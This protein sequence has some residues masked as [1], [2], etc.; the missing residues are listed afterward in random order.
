MSNSLYLVFGDDEYLVGNKARALVDSLVKPEDRAMGLEIIDG[1]VPVIDAAVAAI[2]KCVD[3]VLTMPMFGNAKVTWFQNVNFLSDN[4]VGKSETVKSALES[5]VK[6][7]SKGVPPGQS[8][9]ISAAKVDKRFAFYKTCK[10]KGELHEFAV[11]E[12]S[13]QAESQGRERVAGFLSSAGLSM[14]S[15]AMD[16]FVGRVGYD[17]RQ[18]VN[19]IEKLVVFAGGRTRITVQDIKAVT[20]SSRSAIAWDLSDAIGTRNLPLA[21]ATL[22]QLLFQKEQPVGLIAII[23]SRIK[24]LLIYRHALDRKWLVEKSSYGKPSY[25]WAEL[26]PE[27]DA[28][29]SEKLLKD[30][31]A[32]HPFRIGILAGQARKFT[33]AQLVKCY[34]SVACTSQSLVSGKM[35]PVVAMELLLIDMLS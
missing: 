33:T 2:S 20:S 3:S 32:T 30:P 18:L 12:K 6:V 26:P 34:H 22:R 21:S 16:L 11:S 4:P 19:E 1:N 25:Q 31:R 8:L 27:L 17:S 29:F 23:E 24:E 14:D 9:V 10:E 35:P 15:A 13:W 5:L 7:I 28:I